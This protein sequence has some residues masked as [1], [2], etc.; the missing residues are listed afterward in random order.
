M[1]TN[2]TAVTA[3]GIKWSS[4]STFASAVMQI[5]YTAIMARLLEPAAFGL[6]AMAGVVLR[7]GTYFAQMGMAQAIIQ[8]SS[9]EV[10]DIRAAFTTSFVLGLLVFGIF[11][12]GAPLALLFFESSDQL[13]LII[14]VMAFG[15]F[16]NGLFSTSLSLMRREMNFK[17]LAVIE[18]SSY[19]IAYGGVG[20]L[21]AY[22]GYGVWSLVFATL[23]QTILAGIAAY[24]LI[25]H[26]LFFIFNWKHYKPLLSFGSKVSFIGFMEFLGSNMDTLLIGRWLGSSILGIYNRAYMLVNLPIQYL[27]TSIS[28]VLFPAYSRIQSQ[29]A[30]LKK[31]YLLSISVVAFLMLPACV[32]ISVAAEQIVKL[33]LGDQWLAAIPVLQILALAT[34][35][36]LLAHFGGVVCEAT[37]TLKVKAILQVIYVTALAALIY[38]FKNWGLEGIAFS[39]LLAV[40][41]RNLA[42]IFITKTILNFK[43][44]D[45]IKSYIPGIL[46]SLL[47]G[48]AIYFT[49]NFLKAYD[50]SSGLILLAE[51]IIGAVLLLI[52]F[53]INPD[54]SLKL[55]ISQR[56]RHLFPRKKQASAMDKL[57][58]RTIKILEY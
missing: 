53:F 35:F 17:G 8:K 58:I 45:I 37:A 3:H 43:F 41:S 10:K 25:R 2:L 16:L 46:A 19:I 57:V 22:Q 39:I 21:L 31:I 52:T 38:F 9:L 34:P 20:V 13:V 28:R 18:I 51:V 11:W 7:F 5:G 29:K 27:S 40:F 32:G 23:C 54:K 36:N 4:L 24:T 44:I 15:V 50:I 6:V 49:A 14:R 56:L 12:A 1:S 42:Y 33:V 55:E 47:C 48:L 26:N 30:R